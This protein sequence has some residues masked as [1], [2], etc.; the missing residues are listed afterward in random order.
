M[1]GGAGGAP[2]ARADPSEAPAHCRRPSEHLWCVHEQCVRIQPGKRLSAVQ[3]RLDPACRACTMPHGTSSMPPSPNTY[4]FTP[5]LSTCSFGIRSVQVKREPRCRGRGEQA[6]KPGSSKVTYETVPILSDAA[7]AAALADAEATVD[8]QP[9]D[10][11]VA[12]KVRSLWLTNKQKGKTDKLVAV[13]A[14]IFVP[15]RSNCCVQC[16]AGT[17]CL[18]HSVYRIDLKHAR[19]G[20]R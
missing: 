18:V 1:G 14:L 3:K 8:A 11:I 4:G 15:V 20:K 5:S 17:C 19:V 10:A 6:G 7:V 2:R 9:A 12:V 16:G 13:H